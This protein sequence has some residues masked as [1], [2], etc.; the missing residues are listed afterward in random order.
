MRN[1]WEYA[2]HAADLLADNILNSG[3]GAEEGAKE[4]KEGF[5]YLWTQTAHHS[6]SGPM[7]DSWDFRVA[8][9]KRW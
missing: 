8:Q 4:P 6:Q 2:S 7:V 3:S 9:W 5:E 1:T